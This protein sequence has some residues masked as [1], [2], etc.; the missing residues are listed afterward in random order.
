MRSNRFT[1]AMVSLA[2]LSGIKSKEVK[3]QTLQKQTK[4]QTEKIKTKKSILHNRK[5]Q[6]EL[7]TITW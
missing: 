2:A 7:H 1:F 4:R 6:I 5:K 3:P